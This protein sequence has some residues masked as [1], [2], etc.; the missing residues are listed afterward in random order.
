MSLVQSST[1]WVKQTIGWSNSSESWTE[2][3]VG[4]AVLVCA[5]G[6]WWMGG[7]LNLWQNVTLWCLLVITGA[8]LMRHGWL[9]L[10]GPV[11]FY[12]MLTTARR[13]RYSMIRVLYSFLLV[14][15]LF[16]SWSMISSFNRQSPREEAAQIGM[17]FFESFTVVQLIAVFL[18]TPAYVA[19]SIAEEKERKTLEFLLAT[20]L[21]NREIVLSKFSSRLCNLTMFLL[22]GLPILSFLQFLGGVDPDLVLA[23]FAATGLTIVGIG[24]LSILNSVMYRRPRDAIAMTYF[25]VIAYVAGATVMFVFKMAPRMTLFQEPIWFGADPPTLGDAVDVFNAGNIIAALIKVAEAGFRG[26]LSTV[27]P[28]VLW[29]YTLFHGTVSLV[30]LTWSVVRLRGMALKQSYGRTEK[31]RWHQRFRP[32]VGDL[33]MLWKELNIEGSL[34]VNWLGWLFVILLVLLTVGIGV[35]IVVYYFWELIANP[36]GW[37]GDFYEAMNFWVRIAGSGVGCITLLGVAVRASTTIR[38]EVDKDTFDAL[39]TTPL[40]SDAILLA[41]FVGS[42]FSVRLGWFWLGSILVLGLIT[43]GMHMLALP[44]FLGAWVVYAVFFSM[45]GLWFSMVCRSSMRATV[46]TMLTAIVCGGGHWIIWMCCLPL[47]FLTNLD[48]AGHIPEYLAKFQAGMTPP[49]V[50]GLFAYSPD[51][52]G[53]NFARRE[54]AE[55]MG[56]CLLGLFL[57]VMASLMLWFVLIGPKFRQLTRRDQSS[58]EGD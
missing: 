40:T 12:D 4:A 13:G 48:R 33:P 6:L 17:R 54:F 51:D 2:R 10:F 20:D 18:L 43:G 28:D 53:R 56:F 58:S 44:L 31:L 38:S 49:F 30:C 27:I 37:H 7:R 24:S 1:S 26:T 45:V 19:G 55:L 23:S 39:V 35:W 14:L 42:L 8:V 34:R 46:Y 3:I 57:W 22:T 50:L 52:L 15:V 36:M 21:R 9:K 41:K 47:L 16:W 32:P 5:V 11:L 25:M 29:K